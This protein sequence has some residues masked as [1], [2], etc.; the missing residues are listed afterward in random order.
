MM[1]AAWCGSPLRMLIGVQPVEEHTS[2][3]RME[4][5][6]FFFGADLMVYG[7]VVGG[8]AVAR[9]SLPRLGGAVL[10]VEVLLAS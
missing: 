8:G 2:R 7:A 9:W 5:A 1:D 3:T 10:L 4:A 6:D